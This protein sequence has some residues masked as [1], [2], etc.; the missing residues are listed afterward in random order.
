MVER[1]EIVCQRKRS[2]WWPIRTMDLL[3]STRRA[4]RCVPVPRDPGYWRLL[5]PWRVPAP[6]HR[7]PAANTCTLTWGIS[8][9]RVALCRMLTTTRIA[10]MTRNN[11]HRRT[12]PLST[13]STLRYWPIS[14]NR[15]NLVFLFSPP[16][17]PSFSYIFIYTYIHIC[18]CTRR[19]CLH[20]FFCLLFLP[21]LRFSPFQKIANSAFF[22][23]IDRPFPFRYHHRAWRPF[24][25]DSL[26][27]REPT[28]KIKGSG[29]IVQ[30]CKT[31]IRGDQCL[32]SEN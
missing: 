1:Q 8:S 27:A 26:D 15:V 12:T 23:I 18:V 24:A 4:A 10:P 30:T 22:P 20:H 17:P 28:Q 14:N 32:R 16:L 5:C 21:P 11:T 2:S 31:Q 13:R 25:N 19:S 7:S 9:G 3:R 29:S 6:V